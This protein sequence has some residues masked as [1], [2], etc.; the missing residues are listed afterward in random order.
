MVDQN[1]F[2]IIYHDA[3]SDSLGSLFDD[4]FLQF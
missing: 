2:K 1:S 4:S 3:Y